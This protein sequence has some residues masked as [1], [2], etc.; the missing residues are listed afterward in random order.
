MSTRRD[1]VKRT[2][3]L[4]LGSV[5]LPDILSGASLSSAKQ[6][7]NI[8]IQ[9]YTI[10]NLMSSDPLG[11]LKKLSEIG[12]KNIETASYSKG[13]FYGFTPKELKKVIDD[14]GM[15]WISFHVPGMPRNKGQQNEQAKKDVTT[16]VPNLT[17]D[18]QLLA[19]EA[20]EGGVQ[21]LV[22]ASTAIKTTDQIKAAIE[23]FSKAGEA[24]KKA[25]LHFAYHNHSTEWDNVDGTTAY[26][27]ILSQTDKDLVKMEM[28]LGWVATAKKDPVELFKGNKGRFP[29]WH[30]KDF[31]LET[32][33]IM[34]IGKGTIDFKPAFANAGLAG[35]KYF[36]YEQDNAKSMDDVVLSF[37]NLERLIK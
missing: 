2:G 30:V 3:A 22:C 7:R 19:D 35:M 29:L 10:N 14:L 24:C 25:G 27:M 12:F 9:T 15:K 5:L 28:D 11:T 33:T 37:N 20:A 16:Y 26:D 17:E 4:A 36:F 18:I 6:Q 13:A 1:F 32:R 8:G 21:Y 34:P 31:N 23:T